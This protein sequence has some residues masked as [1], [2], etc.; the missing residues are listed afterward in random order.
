MGLWLEIMI[1]D[2]T[3]MWAIGVLVYVLYVVQLFIVIIFII[4]YE[5]HLISLWLED[6]ITDKTDMWAMENL[7][8]FC[9]LYSYLLL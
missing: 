2:K 6:M 9:K 1:T 5:G 7:S 8:M 3:D 4:L